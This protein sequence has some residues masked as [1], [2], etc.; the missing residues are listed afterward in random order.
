MDETA[1]GGREHVREQMREPGT[2]LCRGAAL[3]LTLRMQT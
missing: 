3:R 1:I 2:L